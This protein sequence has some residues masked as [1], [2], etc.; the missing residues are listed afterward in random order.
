MGGCGCRDNWAPVGPWYVRLH[1]DH[2]GHKSGATE[3]QYTPCP[4]LL[5]AVLSWRWPSF[6][7]YS[8][9]S[10]VT[11]YCPMTSTT[12]GPAY[13][14]EDLFQFLFLSPNLP[15]LSLEPP[16]QILAFLELSCNSTCPWLGSGRHRELA[17]VTRYCS[18]FG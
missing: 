15:P 3:Q 13:Q 8:R 4:C 5:H 1:Q 14:P 7:C 18:C 16:V 11:I 2:L 12:S 9:N 17:A 10:P 6:L